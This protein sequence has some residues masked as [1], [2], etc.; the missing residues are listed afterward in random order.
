[1]QAQ[2]GVT[3]IMND[4]LSFFLVELDKKSIAVGIASDFV[5]NTGMSKSQAAIAEEM[6]DQLRKK[7]C[8]L[9]FGCDERVFI[10]KVPVQRA[11]MPLALPN[12]RK[13]S[14]VGANDA[15][16]IVRTLVRANDV[17]LAARKAVDN[18][19]NGMLPR[20]AAELA[21]QAVSVS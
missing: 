18:L 21:A 13:I 4:D 15:K 6:N 10:S 9:A 14:P 5:D 1:M 19:R 11:S 2:I 17:P 20:R 12:W 16:N 7:L 8:F 3:F